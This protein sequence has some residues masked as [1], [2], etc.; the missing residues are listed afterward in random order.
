MNQRES[1]RVRETPAA[2]R[3]GGVGHPADRVRLGGG[4]GLSRRA[5]LLSGAGPGQRN[6]TTL[7][8]TCC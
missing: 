4:G 3:D 2:R 1:A 5:D 7:T 6:P 8:Q